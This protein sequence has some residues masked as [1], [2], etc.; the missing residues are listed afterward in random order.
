MDDAR[1]AFGLKTMILLSGELLAKRASFDKLHHDIMIVLRAPR[2][3]DRRDVR[4]THLHPELAFAHELVDRRFILPE[5]RAQH[6]NRNDLPRLLIHATED[7]RKRPGPDQ[8]EDSIVPVIEPGRF[9]ARQ[10]FD[11]IFREIPSPL[12]LDQDLIS[13]KR[14]GAKGV[15]HVAQ[16]SQIDQIQGQNTLR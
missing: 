9:A 5:T 15:F 11:L 10:S 4:M 3:V 12:E 16:L 1:R 2:L 6:L 7:A 14:L 13:R 8:I